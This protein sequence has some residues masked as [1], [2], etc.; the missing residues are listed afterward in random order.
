M[1]RPSRPGY[2]RSWVSA[3]TLFAK[4]MASW[5][6]FKRAG[7]DASY[8]IIDLWPQLKASHKEYGAFQLYLKQA[9]RGKINPD[10]FEDID[11]ATL[12][13]MLDSYERTRGPL[14]RFDV[15]WFYWMY[16]FFTIDLVWVFG[17]RLYQKSLIQQ[18]QEDIYTRR[19]LFDKN[20]VEAE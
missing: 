7:R 6:Q 13:Q 2:I 4:D 5:A 8:L 10:D 17:S 11:M 19:D 16:L 18:V 14:M 3:G 12:R 15:R 9:R 20:Y 1:Q